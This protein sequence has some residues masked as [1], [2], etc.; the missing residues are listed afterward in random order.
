MAVYVDHMEA[1]YRGMIMCHMMADTTEEL[2]AMADKIGVKRK[3]IQH[4]GSY[5]EHFDI[6]LSKRA[7]AVAAGA[8]EIG[9]REAGNLLKERLARANET[10]KMPCNQNP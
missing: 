1:A 3:W 2:L 5:M 7:K 9:W 8:K 6:C 10:G 4:Q